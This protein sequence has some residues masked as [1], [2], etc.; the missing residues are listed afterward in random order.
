MMIPVEVQHRHVHLSREHE[1]V[2]FGETIPTPRVVAVAGKKTQFDIVHVVGEPVEETQVELSA[3]DAFALGVD[4]PLRISGDL[5]RSA[6]VTLKGPQGEVEAVSSTIV[7]LRHMHMSPGRA[8]EL[9]V[10][11][12]D[13]VSVQVIGRDLVINHIV[14]LVKAGEKTRL[15]VTMDEAAEYWIHS[16]DTVQLIT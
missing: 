16:N 1:R 13:T 10:A 9:G 11:H 3:S 4:A 14:V 6:S 2:L 12:M 5:I 8:Q 7:P 15:H